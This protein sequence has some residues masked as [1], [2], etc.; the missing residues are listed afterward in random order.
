MPKLDADIMEVWV[1]DEKLSLMDQDEDIILASEKNLEL[2]TE[3]V[4]SEELGINKRTTLLSALCV[5]VYDSNESEDRQLI[6]DAT[7]FLRTNR[8]LF[9]EIGDGAIFDYVKK[10]VYPKIGL[11][12][13]DETV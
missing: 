1:A 13:S 12:L 2:L 5:L 4:T 11:T 3:H 6:E 8:H 10:V 9:K 7:K